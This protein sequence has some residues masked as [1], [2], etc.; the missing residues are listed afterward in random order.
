[1]CVQ[2]EKGIVMGSAVAAD[3]TGKADRLNI[4]TTSRDKAL[5]SLAARAASMSASA[6]VMRAAIR[7]AEEVLADQTR[8]TLSPDKWDAFVK[9]L[10][11]PARE[12]PAL[13]RAAAKG[14]PFS[15]R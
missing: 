14:S 3:S 13:Q 1:M 11:R 2:L 5:V 8:F 15:E 4:R 9:A 12:I 10:D 7:D 6:F